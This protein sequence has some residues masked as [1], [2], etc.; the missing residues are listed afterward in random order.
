MGKDKRARTEQWPKPRHCDWQIHDHS[1]PLCLRWFLFVNRLPASDKYLLLEHVKA[2]TLF[3]DFAGKRVRVV[4]ASRFGDVGITP[5]LKATSGYTTRVTV[6]AL[7]NF[8]EKP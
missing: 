2:P 6:D 4:M 7:S 5:N 1:K 3:A 8:S